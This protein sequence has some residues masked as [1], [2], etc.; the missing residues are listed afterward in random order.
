MAGG[1]KYRHRDLRNVLERASA[2]ETAARVAA[3][4]V[5]RVFLEAL[6]VIINS[7]VV[8]IGEVEVDYKDLNLGNIADAAK[9]PVMCMDTGKSEEMVEA[10]SKAA[11]AG[12]SLGGVFEVLIDNVPAGLGSYVHWDRR[13]DGLLAQ[14]FSVFPALKELNL[15]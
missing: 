15:D 9:S 2:R 1:I 11:Q 5:A 10:I 12:E 4:S 7:H 6:G 13:L 8:R 14:R 3:G